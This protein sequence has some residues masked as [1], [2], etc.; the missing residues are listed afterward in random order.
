MSQTVCLI[1]KIRRLIPSMMLP[2]PQFWRGK[3]KLRESELFLSS[4]SKLRV[5][6]VV[7]S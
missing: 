1:H 4:C 6:K 2:E 5:Q 7:T 3:K